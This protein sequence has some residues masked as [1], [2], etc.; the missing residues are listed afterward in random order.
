MTEIK[1][2]PLINESINFMKK[3]VNEEALPGKA[4]CAVETLYFFL[5]NTQATIYHQVVDELKTLKSKIV[6]LYPNELS[7]ESACEMFIHFLTKG[8]IE[9]DLDQRIKQFQNIGMKVYNSLIKCRDKIV[10]NCTSF[11]RKS[12]T[13]LT[14]GYSKVVCKILT[15]NKNVDFK[16]IVTEGAPFGY[17]DQTINYLRKNGCTFTIEKIPD[18][19]VAYKMK[20]VDFVLIGSQ[21]LVRTGG[22]INSIGTYNIAIIAKHFNVPLYVA[23]ECF[24]FSNSYPLEQKDVNLS[25][26]NNPNKTII[27]DYTPPEM[28]SLVISDLA[29]FTPSAVADELI[30][31]YG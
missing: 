7:T 19:A 8:R 4:L 30:K 21:L 14:H 22:S 17:G 10:Q 27:Y 31:F 20:E 9:G 2:S 16:L 11:V 29:V 28:I 18:T 5:K 3:L 15:D 25:L 6:N 23:A 24:K 13:I 26:F 1:E 12:I